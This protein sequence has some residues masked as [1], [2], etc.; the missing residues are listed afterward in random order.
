[1][2][3]LVLR[4]NILISTDIDLLCEVPSFTST[5]CCGLVWVGVERNT[6]RECR[7]WLDGEMGFGFRGVDICSKDAVGGNDQRILDKVLQEQVCGQNEMTRTFCTSSAF[8]LVNPRPAFR[9]RIRT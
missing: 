2:V 7:G 4:V 5:S 9:T 3:Y 8:R 1:M 6:A